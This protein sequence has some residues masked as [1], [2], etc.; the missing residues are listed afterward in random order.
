MGIANN[1]AVEQDADGEKVIAAL[2]AVSQ[3]DREAILQSQLPDLSWV[4]SKVYKWDDMVKGIEAMY[5]TGVDGDYFWLGGKDD[6]TGEGNSIK[7]GLVSI[8]AF[9]A[10]SM[11]ETIQYDVCDENN[12]DDTSK[13]SAASSCGQVGQSYEDY[14]GGCDNPEMICE[15]DPEMTIVASSTATWYGAPGPMFCAPKSKMPSAPRWEGSG[16]WCDPNVVRDT[17]MTADEY[18]EYIKNGGICR[19]Y[20]GQKDGH[21]VFCD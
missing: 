10:Q 15:V 4:P 21:W 5:R 3:A 8:A 14:R 19:D 13:N 6:K 7:Y 1:E 20:P 17:E 16:A 18:M 2:K 9:L 11:K 12:W